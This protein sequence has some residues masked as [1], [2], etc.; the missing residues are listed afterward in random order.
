MM[1]TPVLLFKYGNKS[2]D[3]NREASR[4]VIELIIEPIFN[5]YFGDK[6]IK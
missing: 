5:L 1:L 3:I 4:S 6:P 2:S